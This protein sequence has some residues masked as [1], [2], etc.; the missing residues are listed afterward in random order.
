MLAWLQRNRGYALLVIAYVLQW[1][2]WIGSPRIAFEYHFF[3]NL[4]IICLADAVL[5]QRLWGA[6]AG[7][8]QRFAWPR[9][10]V[11]AYLALVVALFVFFYPILAGLHVAWSVWDARMWHW[12]MKNQWV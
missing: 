6:A 4:A 5:M 1:L 11:G 10:A 3:P 7:M 8:R 12:L 2:P 9:V